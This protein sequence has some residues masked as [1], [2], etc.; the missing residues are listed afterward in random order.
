MTPEE[1]VWKEELEADIER[2]AKR[3]VR[4][5][6]SKGEVQG[7]VEV[8]TP[9]HDSLSP[10]SHGLDS[11][12]AADG[13]VDGDETSKGSK[14]KMEGGRGLSG[15]VQAP[16]EVPRPG[17]P[18]LEGPPNPSTTVVWAIPK[19]WEYWNGA[20]WKELPPRERLASD[21]S[22]TYGPKCNCHSKRNM[23]RVAKRLYRCQESGLTFE[24]QVDAKSAQ[25]YTMVR[26][27]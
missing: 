4:P 6:F 22:G 23:E 24:F 7:S 26:V 21:G 14:L 3:E 20:L 27:P 16:M 8:R 19:D 11:S 25:G 10:G 15:T 9:L 18:P 12:R 2:E 17:E 13:S 5:V 1:R